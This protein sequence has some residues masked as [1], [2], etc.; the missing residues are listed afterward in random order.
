MIMGIYGMVNV[1][2]IGLVS[3]VQYCVLRE[4]MNRNEAFSTRP[5]VLLV[6]IGSHKQ[7][8]RE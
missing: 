8:C 2:I 3:K 1:S 5:Y 6:R 7:Y 4:H